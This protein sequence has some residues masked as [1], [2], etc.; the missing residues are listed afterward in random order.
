MVEHSFVR[1]GGRAMLGGE[2]FERFLKD[3][4]VCVMARATLEQMFAAEAVNE[5]FRV[6]S[7]HQYER[8]LLFSSVV[9]VMSLVVAGAHPSVHA[10]Y[11]RRKEEIGVSVKSLYNKLNGIEPEVSRALVRHTAD[12]AQ[13]VICRWQ[14]RSPCLKGY[15]TKVIDG[16][17]LTATDHRLDILRD[18]AGAALPGLAVAVLLPDQGLIEDLVLAEDAYTQETRLLKPI[19]QRLMPKDL[20]IADRLYCISEFLFEIQ[21]KGACFIVRQHQGHLR[22]ELKGRRRSRGRTATE[23]LSEQE[24]ELV[25]PQTEEVMRVRRVTIKLAQPTRDGDQELHLLTNLP[26]KAADAAQVAELYRQRWT[27]ETAFQEMTTSLRCEL[28]SLGHPSAALFTFAVAAACFNVLAVIRAALGQAHG[29]QTIDE[30]VSVYALTDELSGTYRGMMIALPPSEWNEFQQMT[31]A[32]LA[33]QLARWAQDVELTRYKKH[34][35]GPKKPTQ[36]P[37]EPRQHVSTA[38][39]LK[40]RKAATNKSPPKYR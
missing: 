34:R 32:N 10:A 26:E 33:Q 25:F 18:E 29:P 40:Q 38:R 9:D 4:P 12:A 1:Q 24:A 14:P 28:S 2:V 37:F 7:E 20:A 16:N 8:E 17:H 19:V 6:H 31:A 35:R 21:A 15:C 39:L 3:A 23:L 36:R 27:I 13:A 30:V 22:W 5:L 11:Q